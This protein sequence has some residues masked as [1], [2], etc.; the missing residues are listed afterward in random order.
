MQRSSDIAEVPMNLID[1]R[2]NGQ[3][4]F[5]RVAQALDEIGQPAS[6]KGKNKHYLFYPTRV[7]NYRHH[8]PDQ[9]SLDRSAEKGNLTAKFR[10]FEEFAAA[11]S[12]T[13]K[14]KLENTVRSERFALRLNGQPIA[15][16]QMTLRYA[17]NGRDTRMHTVTLGPYLEYEVVLNPSQLKAGEN[18]LEVMPT[19]LRPDLKP[20]IHL[21]ELELS[22]VYA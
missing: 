14:C 19:K 18:V 6:L 21:L 13:L 12:I 2:T 9:A 1:L 22:V 16:N 4:D 17:S 11:K 7:Q 20:K 10:C 3:R 15:E 5:S 8:D